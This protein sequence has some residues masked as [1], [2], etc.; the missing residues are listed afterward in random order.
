MAAAERAV[1]FMPIGVFGRAADA[2]PALIAGPAVGT[3]PAASNGVPPSP[4]A[5]G[6]AAQVPRQHR[7]PPD[8]RRGGNA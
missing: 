5:D 7:P 8:L 6:G 2:A 4:P 1:E 3:A